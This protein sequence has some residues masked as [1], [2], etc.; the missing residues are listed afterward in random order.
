MG[1]EGINLTISCELL[2]V[3]LYVDLLGVYIF[4]GVQERTLVGGL[5]I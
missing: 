2:F 5:L 1:G 3:Q 4:S